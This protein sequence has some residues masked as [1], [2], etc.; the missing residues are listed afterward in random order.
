MRFWC[1]LMW[2]E[3]NRSQKLGFVVSLPILSLLTVAS[4]PLGL[5]HLIE[6]DISVDALAGWVFGIMVALYLDRYFISRLPNQLLRV[7]LTL[8]VLVVVGLVS[9]E[10]QTGSVPF[11]GFPNKWAFITAAIFLV[12]TELL[13]D[14]TT[15]KQRRRRRRRTR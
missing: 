6:R 15:R 9:H 12:A 10:M 4:I 7:F 8:S 2:H 3:M 13:N 1:S 14:T 5:M 11:I